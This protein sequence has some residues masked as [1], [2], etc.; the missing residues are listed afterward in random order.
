MT[1]NVKLTK[2]QLKARQFRK[3]K[4]EKEKMKRERDSE[5]LEQE[6]EISGE[7]R[8]GNTEKS[9]EGEPERKKRKMRRG[10]K[11]KGKSD[12]K[13]GNR[14]IVFV[15]NL[16]KD[17]T[18]TELQVHFKSCSPDEIRVRSEKGIAF[19]EFDGEKDASGIQHRMDIALMMHKSQIRGRK[20]N[21][22]LTVG[23]GGNSAQR[24]EKLKAK[25]SKFEE[26]RKRRM[27]KLIQSHHSGHNASSGDS[28]SREAE[29]AT[30]EAA[31]SSVH[32]DRAKLIR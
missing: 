6:N 4:E 30:N 32:P 24:L 7:D 19:L 10:R 2:K 15:G 20:I 13:S 5:E 8:V 29:K 3:S 17:V 26:Q 14:F 22:E 23:G 27:Q 18:E 21:V 9:L 25:N 12:G 11:G 1:E 16:P 31:L 28:H